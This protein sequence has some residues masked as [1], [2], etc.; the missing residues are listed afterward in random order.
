[1]EAEAAAVRE[2]ERR[3]ARALYGEGDEAA[4]RGLMREK[5]LRLLELPDTVAPE[6]DGLEPDTAAMIRHQVGAF[7]YGAEKALRLDSVFYMSA[8]LYPENHRDG[9][10]NDLEAFVAALRRRAAGRGTA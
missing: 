1:M 2:I 8:L 7:S 3:A 5:A 6:L 4:Y 10:D 9:E